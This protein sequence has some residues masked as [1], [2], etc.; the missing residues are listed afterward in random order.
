MPIR[1]DYIERMIQELGE[2][3]PSLPA[4]DC[5]RRST[6]ARGAQVQWLAARAATVALWRRVLL[7]AFSAFAKSNAQGERRVLLVHPSPAGM[8]GVHL[9]DLGTLALLEHTHLA[10]SQTLPESVT[11]RCRLYQAPKSGRDRKVPLTARLRA[12]LRAHR[13]P[14]SELVFWCCPHPPCSPDGLRAACL[15]QASGSAPCSLVLGRG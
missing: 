14:R 6:T 9:F 7:R 12:A 15:P 1:Q 2:K 8:I 3:T 11:R 5:R 13:H 10:V 4:S